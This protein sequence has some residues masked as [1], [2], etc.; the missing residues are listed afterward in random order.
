GKQVAIQLYDKYKV[1]ASCTSHGQL[2]L[3]KTLGCEAY[4]IKFGS[5]FLD[6]KD[7]FTSK[8]ILIFLTPR[9]IL[10]NEDQF[11]EILHQI[12]PE[13]Q[14]IYTSSI[15]VYPKTSQTFTEESMVDVNSKAYQAEEIIRSIVPNAL[16][17][18]LG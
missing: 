2:N 15:S 1:K 5:K 8:A 14:V 4:V 3:L 10:E 11:K 18:R 7:F 6:P 9:A 12:S 17:L 16:I 13:T